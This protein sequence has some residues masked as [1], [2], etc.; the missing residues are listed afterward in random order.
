[1]PDLDEYT[2]RQLMFRSTDD[3]FAS[4]SAAKAAIKRQ[5]Q[6]HLRN[7]ALGATGTA[8][9]AGLAVGVLASGS[10][11]APSG[12]APGVTRDQHL[13]T[14]ETKSPAVPIR[15][16]AAQKVLFSL[17]AAAARTPRPSGRYVVLKEITTTT[18][19]GSSEIG[20]KT[21]VINTITGGGV[22]YQDIS[23]SGVSGPTP[24]GVLNAPAG[25]SPTIAQL[26]ALPT[27]P[28]ALRAALLSQAEQ[29]QRQAQRSEQQN[30]K[31][32]HIRFKAVPEPA[33]GETAAGM[34]FDQATNLLWEPDLSPQL[35][36]AL[37]KVLADTPGVVVRTGVKD[38]SG[39]PATEISRF[40][41]EVWTTASGSTRIHSSSGQ[42]VETFENPATGTTLESAW[43]GRNPDGLN[44]DLYQSISYTNTI[45]PDPYAG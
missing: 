9:A 42:N 40:A 3:L 19:G 2:L 30:L 28:S 17:S 29:Q 26:D 43:V 22:T 39:R 16:T 38:S 20:P 18:G 36:S 13:A 6:R 5:R 37:Y 23:V 15:L 41:P 11:P 45:P 7:R 32:D 8:A 27:D 12:G 21:S 4:P 1:M 25:T 34:V 35:R 10:G 33:S 44:E 31:K 24:P 14:G